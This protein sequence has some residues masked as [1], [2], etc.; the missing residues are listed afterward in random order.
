MLDMHKY[1]VISFFIISLLFVFFLFKS[2]LVTTTMQYFPIDEEAMFEDAKTEISVVDQGPKIEWTTHSVSSEDSYLRQ[3]VSLLYENGKFK[4]VQNKWEQNQRQLSLTQPFEQRHSSLL[5]SISFHHGEI[6]RTN[7]QINSIQQ[8]TSAQLYFIH[9]NQTIYF[10][11]FPSN[12]FEKKW[13]KKLDEITDQQLQF[14]WNNL[15]NHLGIEEENYDSIP[16]TA[17]V[18]YEQ[19]A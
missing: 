13:A 10:F 6:H 16:L 2:K 9:D 17:L 15:I 3:D 1:L 14:H 5:Q 19:K 7:D 8:M 11:D 12:S 4:G 18:Q